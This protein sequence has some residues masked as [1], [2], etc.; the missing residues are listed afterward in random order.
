VVPNQYKGSLDV[1]VNPM[2]DLETIGIKEPR[3]GV[4]EEYRDSISFDGQRYSMKL[5]WKE[6]HPD[7][8]TNYTTSMCRIKSQVTRLEREPKILAEY[9]AIIEEQ[10]HTVVIERVVELEAARKVHYLP[11][12]AVVR[13]AYD[14]LSKSTKTGASL[15]DCLHVGLSLNIINFVMLSLD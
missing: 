13:I 5:P 11:H 1:D 8:P 4:Y 15:S 7:L 12:Q 2:W 6:G 9:A 14:A 10:L 3:S